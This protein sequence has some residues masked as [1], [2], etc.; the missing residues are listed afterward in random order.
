MILT[1]EQAIPLIELYDQGKYLQSHQK[2]LQYGPLKEWGGPRGRMIAARLAANLGAPRASRWHRLRAWRE[3]PDDAEVI[4]YYAFTR[5]ES[6]GPYE[7][8]R[9]LNEQPFPDQASPDLHSSWLTLFGQTLTLLRDFDSAEEWLKRAEDVS[10][11]SPW[12]QIGWSTFFEDQDRYDEALHAAERSLALR[13]WYRPAVQAKGHLLTLLGQ[14]DEACQFLQAASSRLESAAVYLSLASILLEREAYDELGV[15]LQKIDEFSPLIENGFA[16]GL[17]GLRSL[18]AY[19]IGDIEGAINFARQSDDKFELKMADRLADPARRERRCVH[20]PVGFVRQHEKTCVPATLSTIS[21]F[22]SM[23]AEHLQIAEAICYDGTSAYNERHWADSHGWY[24]REFTVSEE[25]AERLIEAGI[26][27]TLTTTAPGGG[28]LQAVIGYDGRRGTL[29]IRDPYLRNW[30]EGFADSLIEHYQAFGPRGMALVPVGE[31]S[32]LEALELPD[33][34]LWDHL[35]RLDG[36]LEAHQRDQAEE[37]FRQLQKEASQHRIA[38]EAER[39]LMIYDGNPTGVLSALDKLLILFP[40]DALL[41]LSRLSRLR[42]LAKRDERVETLQRLC[43][44]KETHPAFLNQLAQELSADAREHPRAMKLLK[45]AMRLNPRDAG[46]Y[47][48]RA[49]L[50]CDQLKFD[51]SLD[52]YRFAACLDDKNEAAAEA[53]FRMAQYRKQ[54]NI[55]LDWIRRRVDRFGT[56]SSQPARTLDWALRRLCRDAEGV[57]AIEKAIELRPDDGDLLLYAA[58]IETYASFSNIDRAKELYRRAEGR[59]A[60]TDWLRT[61]ARLASYQSQHLEALRIWRE[62][63]ELQPMAVDAHR[64]IASI[65]S[66]IEGQAAALAHVRAAA[67]RFPHHQPLLSLWIEW[68][69]E[70][71]VAVSEPVIRRLIELNPADAWAQRE[72][73]FLLIKERRFEEAAHYAEEAGR[74]DPTHTA[75]FHLRGELLAVEGRMAEARREYRGAL[76]LSIDNNFAMNELLACCETTAE[77]LEEL[78]FLRQELTKQVIYGDGLLNY[79]LC[80]SR[81]LDPDQLLRLLREAL[82][83]RPDLWH[84]W[85]ASVRQLCDMNQLDDALELVTQATDRFPLMPRIWMDRATVCQLRLDPDAEL[86]ALEKCYEINPTWTEVTRQLSDLYLRKSDFAKA[87]ELL[88]R[89]IVI[90][91][92]DGMNYGWLADLQWRQG[93]R[94]EAFQNIERAVELSPGYSWA[95]DCL[96]YWSNL[97]DQS[98]RP[99]RVARAMTERRPGEARSWLFLDRMMAGNESLLEERLE[100]LQKAITL[101]PRCIAAFDQ[102]ARALHGAGRTEEALAACSPP[103]FGDHRPVDL[104]ACDAWI[105]WQQGQRDRAIGEM[106]AA[107]KQDPSFYAGWSQLADWLEEQHD[108]P[109]S[110]EASKMMVRLN[111]HTEGSLGHLAQALLNNGDRAEAKDA[112]RRAF[113][114]FPGYQY[115]GLWLFDLEVEDNQFDDAAKTLAVLETHSTGS[116]VTSKRIVLAARRKDRQTAGIGLRE[117]CFDQGESPWPLRT[118][119]EAM[120]NA[121]WLADVRR[122]AGEAIDAE[123]IHPQVGPKWVL[124]HTDDDRWDL[125]GRLQVLVERHPHAGGLAVHEWVSALLNKGRNRQFKRFVRKDE[126]WLRKHS[127]AWG[128]VG[129]GFTR[130]KEYRLAYDWLQDW[131]DQK[132]PEPWMLVNAVEA[133]RQ[134]GEKSEA[135]EIS[136]FALTLP[137]DGGTAAHRLWLAVDDIEHK[138]YSNA[139]QQLSQVD[140]SQLDID[141]EFLFA[142]CEAI[143]DIEETFSEQR[144]SVFKSVRER[145]NQAARYPNFQREKARREFFRYAVKQI[146]H[147]VGGVGATLWRWYRI[148]LSY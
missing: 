121:H 84:A 31:R 65:L 128:S 71:P 23:P 113:E 48:I 77:R 147:R 83:A 91:P 141:F 19:R 131:R 50:L 20:L 26:P 66:E 52:L 85:S 79:R 92:M 49:G 99:L 139:R 6:Q 76:R 27:F 30:S 146:S 15:V 123:A 11:S 22:W 134:R 136:R 51:E 143:L 87:A 5:L 97:T 43:D 86:F 115:A 54:T 112:F 38:L 78:E 24:T 109:G 7:T 67:E 103:V 61:G 68:L 70:E 94:D 120:S 122:I 17:A 118:A 133:F 98:D 104:L 40:D 32:R 39:R 93:K 42:E 130:L 138:K 73:G 55:A 88:T 57:E 148:G 29:I 80:A 10:P 58:D 34:A 106:R 44:K 28:H 107:V 13:E 74:L 111:P 36:A 105:Q 126:P 59:C 124:A 69:H 53:Y 101:E 89:A 135:T 60:R 129:W 117:L 2:G 142:L 81:L 18:I 3:T 96:R 144:I 125:N 4:Y 35:H 110:L 62:I 37:V 47:Y 108:F 21:Q 82:E 1:E 140:R 9:F 45:R 72:L 64:A 100:V 46:N 63:V 145:L 95:W 41:Q 8:W 75:C 14:D 90:S 114:L 116:F 127:F 12:V 33:A 56:K 137:A 102:M 16:R 132:E 25:S 119:Y